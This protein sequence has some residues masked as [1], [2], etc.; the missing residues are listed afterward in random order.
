M[1]ALYPLMK[2]ITWWPQIWL[3]LTFN[4]GVLVAIAAARGAITPADFALYLALIFWTLGYDTIYAIQDREDDALIGVKS[5]ARRFG[6]ADKARCIGDLS[7]LRGNRRGGRMDGRWLD[8]LRRRPALR[9]ASGPAG[10]S[11]A[12]RRRRAGAGSLPGQS[13]CRI[14]AV[15][16][17][18]L[19]RSAHLAD[20]GR[21]LGRM[22]EAGMALKA[23]RITLAVVAIAIIAALI[24]ARVLVSKPGKHDEATEPPSAILGPDTASNAPAAPAASPTQLAQAPPDATP[25]ANDDPTVSAASAK[26][27]DVNFEDAALKFHAVLP[28]GPPDDPVIKYLREDAGRTLSHMKVNAESEHEQLTQKG[29]TARPWN[30]RIRWVYTAKAAGLVSLAGEEVEF[31]GGAHPNL[32]FDSHIAP[33]AGGPSIKVSDMMDAGGL[34][35]PAMVIGICEELKYAK[36]DRIHAKTIFDDPIVCA[37]PN[38]NAKTDAAVLALAPSTNRDKFGGVYVYYPPYSVG[39]NSEGAYRFAVQQ[40]VFAADLKPQYKPNVRR[41]RARPASLK[42]GASPAARKRCLPDTSVSDP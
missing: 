30:V 6:R 19:H 41:P 17:L 36:L 1:V 12:S 16:R 26:S 33:A 23:S 7:L 18:G 35:S 31:K 4:W 27:N 32:Y 3:G 11:A 22:R 21:W 28:P 39:P 40:S 13:G 37:G 20:N 14:T 42:S 15:C 38:A 5:T 10:D 2:R 8:R 29:D 24:G 25:S 9:T 34:L